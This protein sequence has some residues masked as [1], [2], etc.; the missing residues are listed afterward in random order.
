MPKRA[1]VY[2][3]ANI[4]LGVAVLVNT[5][6]SSWEFSNSRRW[7]SYLAIT[8]LASMWKVPLPGLTG[9]I[10]LNFLFI[11]IGVS[12]FTLSETVLI[13]CAGA[14]VQS[15]WRSK[16]VPKPSQF[17]FNVAVLATSVSLAYV[18][19]HFLLTGSTHQ[20]LP[21]LLTTAATVYFFTNTLLISGVISLV[22]HRSLIQIW[23][24]CHLWTF[25]YY[26]AGGA[27][28]GLICSSSRT[29]GWQLPLLF[30]PLVYFVYRF[31]RLYVGRLA[32]RVKGI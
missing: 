13:A 20:Y 2:I 22:E 3:A 1:K 17:S 28:A 29:V 14:L 31:Y 8:V 15:F 30:L 12:D 18:T 24:Q 9:T 5:V 23:Q 27:I 32:S 19:T 6:L 7:A 10:S 4:V 25:P 16:K 11:L 21:L 26:V